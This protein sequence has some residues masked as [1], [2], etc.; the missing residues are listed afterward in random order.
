MIA[1]E[2]EKN[3]LF[4]CKYAN[5]KN[6]YDGSEVLCQRKHTAPHRFLNPDGLFSLGRRWREGRR[7][8]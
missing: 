3:L 2:M 7:D 8:G 5:G 4:D 6:C 1:K